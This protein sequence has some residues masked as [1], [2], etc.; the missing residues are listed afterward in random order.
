MISFLFVG[1]V[2]AADT[3]EEAF[4]T[5]VKQGTDLFFA[6]K[7]R[8]AIASYDAAAER[9]PDRAAQ[10]WQRGIACYYA[11]D[12]AR[13]IQQFAEHRTVNPDDVEN[14]VWHFLCTA[15]ADSPVT[16]KKNLI[17]VSDDD[18]VPMKELHAFYAGT[19]SEADVFRAADDTNASDTDRQKRRFYAHLYIGLY[20]DALGKDTA[21]Q[22]LKIAAGYGYPFFMGRMAVLHVK[23][24][25]W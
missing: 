17:P 13:G 1:A 5:A 16:A 15:K 21:K 2:C 14:A 6:G 9:Y 12:H 19:G 11:G 8:E 24:R 10:L 23:L 3:D 18:R 25:G 7:V 22:H 4:K 20:Y